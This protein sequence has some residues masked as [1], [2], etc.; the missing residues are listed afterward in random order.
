MSSKHTI[1]SLI[2][3]LLLISPN[4]AEDTNNLEEISIRIKKD[5]SD[6]FKYTFE[7]TNI[8]LI[9]KKSTPALYDICTV[10]SPN[11]ETSY[12]SPP[13]FESSTIYLTDDKLFSLK[14]SKVTA[15]LVEESLGGLIFH[16]RGTTDLVDIAGL[17]HTN[18]DFGYN[19]IIYSQRSRYFFA[20]VDKSLAVFH[21]QTS[22]LVLKAK[23]VL[24][25][26]ITKED[27]DFGFISPNKLYIL[28]KKTGTVSVNLILADS[29]FAE[30]KTIPGI[31]YMFS[32]EDVIYFVGENVVV[33]ENYA[34]STEKKAIMPTSLLTEIEGRLFIYSEFVSKLEARIRIFDP[35]ID[36]DKVE[37]VIL[38]PKKAKQIFATKNNLFVIY[39][40]WI[41]IFPM[42]GNYQYSSSYHHDLI[43]LEVIQNFLTIGA[44]D[45]IIIKDRTDELRIIKVK[46]IPTAIECKKEQ[47]KELENYNFQI[48][49]WTTYCQ[50]NKDIFRFQNG[51]CSFVQ[52]VTLSTDDGFIIGLWHLLLT[53]LAGALSGSFIYKIVVKTRTDEPQNFSQFMEESKIHQKKP[54]N[55]NKGLTRVPS[56]R[57]N[58][59]Q[60][61][62]R[63]FM[64]DYD[65]T[66]PS[67]EFRDVVMSPVEDKSKKLVTFETPRFTFQL[68]SGSL[69][70]SP[71]QNPHIQNS[72]E[73]AKD[74]AK[75]KEKNGESSSTSQSD[76]PVIYDVH[77]TVTNLEEAQE[78]V[79]VIIQESFGDA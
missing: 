30:I 48:K 73:K 28:D 4:Q 70:A 52:T 64:S 21:E 47:D 16:P 66:V 37:P 32:E 34:K 60:L 20:F 5:Y 43:Q 18:V 25:N 59:Q 56:N 45:Y 46:K 8:F 22:G 74:G 71:S 38:C 33:T 31:K 58:S 53:F 7:D 1:L 17:P 54:I 11:V 24:G 77:E 2:F 72:D 51:S 44:Q 62:N 13:A 50:A 35:V 40:S 76:A 61:E 63:K 39:D 68:H 79:P 29:R 3:L 78:T 57:S 27:Y 42:V 14:T 12:I 69:N 55:L 41:R 10:N 15:C 49:F 19:N 26:T 6:Y 75:E 65:D 67:E 36:F 9:E 23:I